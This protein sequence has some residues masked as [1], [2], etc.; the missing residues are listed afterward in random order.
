MIGESLDHFAD[1]TAVCAKISIVVM[2]IVVHTYGSGIVTGERNIIP[3]HNNVMASVAAVSVVGERIR[4]HKTDY[5]LVIVDAVGKA[6]GK[7]GLGDCGILIR[8]GTQFAI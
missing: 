6:V 3:F 1:I 8:T 4:D 5:W 2:R 7:G